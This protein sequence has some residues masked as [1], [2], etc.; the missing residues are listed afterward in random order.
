M[1]R[2]IQPTFSLLKEGKVPVDTS[3]RLSHFSASP[4]QEGT[5]ANPY[6]LVAGEGDDQLF[7]FLNAAPHLCLTE[8]AGAGKS[9]ATRLLTAF[10]SSPNG[11][12]KLYQGQPC[13]AIR[14]EESRDDWPAD[15]LQELQRCLRPFVEKWNSTTAGDPQTTEEVVQWALDGGRVFLI[16]DGLDQ[17]HDAKRLQSIRSFLRNEGKQARIL[18][19]GR[20]HVVSGQGE[21]QQQNIVT[22]ISWRFGR[23][24]PFS[25]RDQY[26]YL[27]DL[28]PEDH[29]GLVGEGD[30][31]GV[32][33]DWGL[34]DALTTRLPDYDLV[35]DLLSTPVILRIVRDVLQDN[36]NARFLS[37]GE[38]YA[39]ASRMTIRRAGVKL[40]EQFQWRGETDIELLEQISAAVAY[41][42]VVQCAWRYSVQGSDAVSRLRNAAAD[43][44]GLDDFDDR[45]WSLFLAATHATNRAVFE[46]TRGDMISFRHRG[47]ME[48]YAAQHLVLNKQSQWR[49]TEGPLELPTRIRCGDRDLPNHTN[50]PDWYWVWRFATE[51]PPE[52][53][54]SKIQIASL[55][56][57][58]RQPV[59]EIRPTELIYRAWHLFELNDLLLKQRHFRLRDGRVV[60]GQDLPIHSQ[61]KSETA[62]SERQTLRAVLGRAMLLPGADV[63]LAEFR[64]SSRELVAKIQL[65]TKEWNNVPLKD[66][67]EHTAWLKRWQQQ[68]SEV[69]CHTFLQCPPQSWVKQDPDACVNVMGTRKADDEKPRHRIR[70]SP[71]ELQATPVTR[72]QYAVFDRA[73]ATSEFKTS[74]GGVIW[75]QIEKYAASK[76]TYLAKEQPGVD[77]QVVMT[78]WYDAWV[79]C[80][81]LG[82]EY[83]LPTDCQHEFGIRGGDPGDSCFGSVDDQ[84][85][86]IYNSRF[87]GNIDRHSHVV[88]QKLKLPN[89]YGLYDVDG[90]VW[91][92]SWDWYEREWNAR[93]VESA[94]S[95]PVPEDSGPAWGSFR[96]LCGSK[97]RSGIPGVRDVNGGFRCVRAIVLSQSSSGHSDL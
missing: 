96:L 58:F 31:D 49:L 66:T 9:V 42:M 88:G 80:K 72:G 81:W 82:P 57:L 21:I 45:D 27:E 37:R 12:E 44:C 63:V 8:D 40:A 55:S 68:P 79:Y 4:V 69:K 60:F 77:C 35:A 22:G 92:W 36:N 56:E 24:N 94:L 14:F 52:L 3:G 15:I 59:Q 75:E 73:F 34:K 29:R 46:A 18:L 20:S 70:V 51:I 41:Q 26:A 6:E 61:G 87:S 95:D 78:S 1:S 64:E 30:N 54:D 33:N 84:L 89:A 16:L 38:L 2:L 83:Q 13:L 32:N 50:D 71:F 65:D 17:V 86:L 25:L 23:V 19:T 11:Y 5:Q 39:Q 28:L 10:V 43:R 85:I 74:L 93:R 62:E 90:Q 48:F 76:P 47:F 91:E 53:C 7:N 67:P 97:C